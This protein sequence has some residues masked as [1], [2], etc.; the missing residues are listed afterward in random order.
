MRFFLNRVPLYILIAAFIFC[1]SGC[2]T[3][4][5]ANL[6]RTSQKEIPV[7]MVKMPDKEYTELNYLQ[8]D[9][10]VFTTHEK[11]LKKLTEKAKKQGADAVINVK[12]GYVFWIPFVTGVAIKYK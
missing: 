10:T 3:V 6:Q 4:S 12:Y 5:V 11:L 9:G 7:Y 8:A 1:L 2:V